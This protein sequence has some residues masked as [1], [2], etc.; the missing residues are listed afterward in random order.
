MIV[1]R[2]IFYVRN[3]ILFYL[4]KNLYGYFIIKHYIK[5]IFLKY[6]NQHDI[7]VFWNRKYDINSYTFFKKFKSRELGAEL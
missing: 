7:R 1:L 6:T 4:K 5:N 2:K 3:I